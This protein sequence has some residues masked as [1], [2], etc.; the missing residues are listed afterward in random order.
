MTNPTD[1]QRRQA[2]LAKLAEFDRAES[3]TDQLASLE[4]ITAANERLRAQ[5]EHAN[6]ADREAIGNLRARIRD[7]EGQLSKLLRA[8]VKR[9]RKMTTAP[10]GRLLADE[11]VGIARDAAKKAQAAE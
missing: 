11:I 9:V 1:E 10:A 7:R 4:Q 2:S 8:P 5:L 6:E 3:D